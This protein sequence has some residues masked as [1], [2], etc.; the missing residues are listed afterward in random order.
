MATTWMEVF[1]I[2]HVRMGSGEVW[3]WVLL[4]PMMSYVQNRS[5]HSVSVWVLEALLALN[6][7][8]SGILLVAYCIMSRLHE[9]AAILSAFLASLHA[10]VITAAIQCGLCYCFYSTVILSFFDDEDCLSG[11]RLCS[12]PSDPGFPVVVMLI[13]AIF[14]IFSAYPWW[15]SSHSRLQSQSQ[16]PKPEVTSFM[17]HDVA[18]ECWGSAC[19]ICLEDVS[20]DCT[21]GRLQ[22]GHTFHYDCVDRWMRATRPLA[23]CPMRCPSNAIAL[24]SRS[25]SAI[26][27]AATP[28]RPEVQGANPTSSHNEGGL[29]FCLP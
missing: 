11:T 8:R 20:A 29:P 18:S 12:D 26:G 25:P 19:V 1:E 2:L 9:T 5:A 4:F 22:C 23:R 15:Q 17:V 13:N 16:H 7:V 28:L 6:V 10:V 24:P 27:R 3:M 21:A 14:S